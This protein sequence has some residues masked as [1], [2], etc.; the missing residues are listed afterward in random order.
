[1]TTYYITGLGGFVGCN[2][3]NELKGEKI[4]AFILPSE[5]NISYLQNKDITLVEGNILNKDDVYRFLSTKGEGKKVL[6]HAAGRITTLKHGDPLTMS[7]NFEGTKNIV[8]VM[9]EIGGFDKFVYVSSVDAMPRMKGTDEISE[10]SYYDIDKVEGAY[11]KSKVLASNYVLDN[12]KVN[13]TIVLPSAIMGP[14]DPR[15]APINNAIKKFINKKLPA[16]TSGG[17]NIVDVRDVAKG[18]KLAIDKGRDKESYLLTGEYI[19]VKDLI[20][21]AASTT[22][23]KPIKR[24]V[25]HFL[26]KIASPFIS[27]HA[28]IH[29]KTPLF[30][31]FSMD[32]L[33]QNSFYI[34]KKAKDELGYT[35]RPL[36][37]TMVDTIKW[38][39]ESGYLEK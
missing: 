37:E 11:S 26:I 35:S 5:R 1:M 28:K 33:K 6:V 25:P 22:N 34:N 3:L 20:A 31:G 14:N 32:C 2:L 9:N 17:Y 36:K 38:M 15:L 13:S 30:T 29:H 18:I 4:I 12:S 27:L 7:I 23:T 10:V 24:K 8:D 19:S 39:K 16:I 21:L